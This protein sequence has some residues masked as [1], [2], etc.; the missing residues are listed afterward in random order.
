[1]KS[2]E[3]K[4]YLDRFYATSREEEKEGFYLVFV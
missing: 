2:R 3:M 4:L 1:M